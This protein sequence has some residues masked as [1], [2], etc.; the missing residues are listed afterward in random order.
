MHMDLAN[1]LLDLCMVV[2]TWSY[3]LHRYQNNIVTFIGHG[4]HVNLVPPHTSYL[5]LSLYILHHTP[6]RENILC[7]LTCL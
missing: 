4:T 1:A 3:S 7:V 6:E 2:S 5:I